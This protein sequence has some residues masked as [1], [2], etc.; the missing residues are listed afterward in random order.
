VNVHPV[1]FFSG[2]MLHLLCIWAVPSHILAVLVFIASGGVLASLNH[3]RFDVRLPG[4]V[5]EVRAHDVHH[6][7]PNVRP[8]APALA[9]KALTLDP[10]KS[11]FG[12]VRPARPARVPRAAGAD[13]PAVHHVDGQAHGHVPPLPRAVARVQGVACRCGRARRRG[14]RRRA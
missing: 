12:Q 5:Y 2:E 4:G 14:P 6:H 7:L 10:R 1:E 3:T 9:R 11:N 8:C 13:A